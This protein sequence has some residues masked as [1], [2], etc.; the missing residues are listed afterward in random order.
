MSFKH[1]RHSN[2]FLVKLTVIVGISIAASSNVLAAGLGGG[3]GLGGALG[4]LGE[5]VGGV[6]DG[7]GGVIGGVGSTVDGTIGGVSA[8]VDAD[9]SGT[10]ATA[11]VGSGTRDPS[12]R[13]AL[14]S[15]DV[16][17]LAQEGLTPA[18]RE[19]LASVGISIGGIVDLAVEIGVNRPTRTNVVNA[20]KSLPVRSRNAA[21]VQCRRLVGAGGMFNN[22]MKG[23]C[24]KALS[25]A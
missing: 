25:A 22:Q 19:A 11:N 10:N 4:G 7:V 9:V 18:Q 8:S 1:A 16:G 12:V 20:L 2:A 17:V 24:S 21:I 15:I 6:V 3:G 14:V 23:V 13:K 5:S